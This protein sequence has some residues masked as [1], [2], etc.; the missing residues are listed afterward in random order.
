MERP[1]DV[2][3]WPSIKLSKRQGLVQLSYTSDVDHA[4]FSG[5]GRNVSWRL[6]RASALVALKIRF[7]SLKLLNIQC[8]I[9]L[10]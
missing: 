4:F 6:H 9:A 1:G 8:I 5:N 10:P 7:Y 3:Y 2:N